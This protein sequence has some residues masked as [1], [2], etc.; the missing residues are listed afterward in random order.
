MVRMPARPN[1]QLR[2]L[3]LPAILEKTRD[4]PSLKRLSPKTV[5]EKALA[6]LSAVIGWADDQGLRDGNPAKGLKIKGGKYTPKSRL[7]YSI[8][9]LNTDFSLSHFHKGERPMGGAGE[10]A[11]WL[12][13]LGLFTG[14]RLEELGQL[15]VQDV[16]KSAEGIWFLDMITLDKGQRL[17]N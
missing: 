14:A 6:T 15:R 8:D 4:D 12:P 7:S 13:L 1:W 17:K 16:Q 10:A 3:S 9:E 11:K 2:A 5:N